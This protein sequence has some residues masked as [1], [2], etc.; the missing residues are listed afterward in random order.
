MSDKLDKRTINGNNETKRGADIKK[1]KKPAG[2]YVL[3]D[4][5][6]AGLKARLDMLIE[7]YGNP[8]EVARELRVPYGTVRHWMLRGMV[9]PEGAMR[10]HRAYQR[11]GSTGFTALSL[12]PDLRFGN[13]GTPITKRCDRREMLRV[14]TRAEVEAKEALAQKAKQ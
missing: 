6:R 11:N 7:F 8:A 12:R 14:V 13:N 3:K 9:S 1:R 2:Y 10:A 5:V 4:E